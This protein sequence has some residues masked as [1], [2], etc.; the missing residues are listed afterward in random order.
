MNR[1]TALIFYFLSA[2]VVVQFIWWGYHII[3]LTKDVGAND[4][5]SSKR[6]TMILGEGSVFLLILL[7]GIFQIRKSIKKDLQL[8]RRQNNFLLSITHELKTPIAANKL[9]LQTLKKRALSKEQTD[10]IIDKSLGEVRRLEK[11]IENL[12]SATR[13]E[14][15]SLRLERNTFT[16]NS[17]LDEIQ[18]RYNTLQNKEIITVDCNENISLNSDQFMLE[19]VLSN[20]IENAVKYAGTEHKIIL[21]AKTEKQNVVLN[22]IDCGPGIPKEHRDSIFTKFYRVENEETRS[23][24]GTGLGLFIVK[25][26]TKV[27]GGTVKYIANS[28]SGSNFQITLKNDE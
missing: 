8:S 14:N 9:Y 2:Y 22:I 5:Q 20:L 23:H 26:L 21:K 13:L 19:T 28:P 12:L 25:E 24:K 16:I 10:N 17:L 3:E 7:T 11:L 4:I 15:K 27:L 18:L 1:R 6:I